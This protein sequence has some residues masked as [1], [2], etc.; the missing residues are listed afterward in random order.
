MRIEISKL[1][2]RDY[3]SGFVELM[4]FVRGDK[5]VYWVV[6]VERY[7]KNL[8]YIKLQSFADALT[9]FAEICEKYRE[10]LSEG[11]RYVKLQLAER[12]DG[13]WEF[14][15]D[16][17]LPS[18]FVRDPKTGGERTFNSRDEAINFGRTSYA[19]WYVSAEGRYQIL[20]TTGHAIDARSLPHINWDEIPPSDCTE[21]RALARRI[22][23]AEGNDGE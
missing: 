20:D 15:S 9:T 2:K 4:Q 10:Q 17:Q 16:S 7:C 3:V 8:E 5:E 12:Q 11:R 23:L 6:R 18:A 22:P 21:L 13:L 1:H 19:R 14:Q